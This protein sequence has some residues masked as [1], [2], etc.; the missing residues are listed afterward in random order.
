MFDVRLLFHNAVC[1]SLMI[2]VLSGLQVVHAQVNAAL[3]PTFDD[4]PV[5][6]V[7][8]RTP[9]PPIL[10]TPEQRLF[11]TRIREGVEKGWGV[12]INGEWGNETK[13]TGAEFCRTLR[14]HRLGLRVGSYQD[15]RRHTRHVAPLFP[16]HS[17]FCGRVI[18]GHSCGASQ[19]KSNTCPTSAADS[20][21]LEDGD[22][23]V[24]FLEIA[25]PNRTGT[26]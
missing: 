4:Y 12:W 20:S 2:A 26:V 1:A 16:T 9:H 24:G 21:S 13:K 23:Y 17:T 10:T 22:W 15:G 6:E 11:R 19:S 18:T 3:L 14:C 8:N 5:R 25:P 7:F